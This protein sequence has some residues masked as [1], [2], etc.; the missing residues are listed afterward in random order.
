MPAKEISKEKT[1]QRAESIANFIELWRQF[2]TDRELD[3]DASGGIRPLMDF[4]WPLPTGVWRPD[5]V[6]MTSLPL[7]RIKLQCCC[8]GQ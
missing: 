8:Y 7:R 4:N 6:L 5:V 2:L 1:R 3:T